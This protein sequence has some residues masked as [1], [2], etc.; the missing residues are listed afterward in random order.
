MTNL[1]QTSN[2]RSNTP[3]LVTG[4]HRSGTTWVGKMLAASKRVAY[5]SE[6]LNVW[7]RPGVM[8]AP[9]KRWYLYI[10]D[11]N[12]AEYSDA[13]SET[14]SF[15]YHILRELKSLTSVKD[16]LRMGRDASIF[17]SG[18]IVRRRPLL[19]DPFALFSATWFAS[20][21]DCQVVI[22]VR[23]PA[24]FASSFKRLNWTFDFND[25]LE[26][27]RLMEDW[28]E[29]FR[30]D[31]HEAIQ[32]PRDVIGQAC[33]LWRMIYWVVLQYQRNLPHLLLVR[34]EDLSLDPIQGFSKLYEDLGLPFTSR[35]Q[36]DIIKSSSSDNPREL[37]NRAHAVRLD[38]QANLNNWKH[39]LTQE[40][41]HR[42][43][44]LTGE[45]AAQYYPDE[46]W[47]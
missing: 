39:R 10:C 13:I 1:A 22:T 46:D 26:Q 17:L 29:P 33:L 47:E 2:E 27:P 12:E 42:V 5:I 4:A 32:N 43:R 21:F 16:V 7:H 31:M 30:D 9:V 6:P 28:L 14:L 23:H 24:A 37:S 44:Q 34:H 20:R 18:K 41:I 35:V 25:L 45:V 15:H 40:E 36:Q 38:S 19:K 3:I 8:R 11:Y